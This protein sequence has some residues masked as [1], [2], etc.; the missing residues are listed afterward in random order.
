MEEEEGG[1]GLEV[2]GFGGVFL[3]EV[4]KGVLEERGL[5][6]EEEVE[7]EEEDEEEA[8][9]LG[10]E[11]DLREEERVG[12]EEDEEVTRGVIVLGNSRVC[13]E[14]NKKE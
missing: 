1:S 2:S 8:E 14:I 10:R 7:E 5:E 11:R 3:E 12:A 9:Y 6:E 13:G 4:P